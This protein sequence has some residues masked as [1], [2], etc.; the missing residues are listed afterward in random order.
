MN[1]QSWWQRLVH[2]RAKTVRRKF[3]RSTRR[4]EV[5]QLES[6]LVPAPFHVTANINIYVTGSN[7]G[8]F[9]SVRFTDPNRFNDGSVSGLQ[10]IGATN[11]FVAVNLRSAVADAA[12]FGGSNK[13]LLET[14]PATKPYK[15]SGTD[16]TVM[17][18][19]QTALTIEN[20]K[21]GS[22]L[23]IIDAQAKSRIFEIQ[24]GGTTTL[25]HLQMQNGFAEGVD[26]PSDPG[27]ASLGGAIFM[28]V[29]A[30]L[31]LSNDRLTENT[32][33]GVPGDGFSAAGGAIFDSGATSAGPSSGKAGTPGTPSGPINLKI[34]NTRVDHNSAIASGESFGSA[35]GAEGGGLCVV[36][37]GTVAITASTF[38][39]NSAVGGSTSGAEGGNGGFAVGAGAAFDSFGNSL[40]VSVANSTFAKNTAQ[41]G[42][43][44]NSSYGGGGNAYGGGLAV[45]LSGGEGSASLVNSTV[46]FN[47][48]TGGLG[49]GGSN[50]TAYGG[51]VSLLGNVSLGVL[52]TI[53]AKNTGGVNTLALKPNDLASNGA[54]FIDL[55]HNL[56]GATDGSTGFGVPTDFLGTA[57]HPIDP[58][59]APAGLTNNGGPTP[60]IAI[61]STSKAVNG[62]SDSVVT[63][64]TPYSELGLLSLIDDQRGPGFLRESGPHVDIGAFELSANKGRDLLFALFG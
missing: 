32:A 36:G 15:L 10:E 44:N 5:E 20:M 60:T 29:D 35:G 27:F 39:D 61:L 2:S 51:G 55:G 42:N 40:N 47:Q 1:T 57:A 54:P 46:A 43:A 18:S 37:G 49:S 16:L 64:G 3:G 59:F 26:F 38:D 13:I 34:V 7:G 45:F 28:D 33:E 63:G 4:M 14:N 8:N 17:F 53:V 9:T 41:A 62:G 52:N 19:G 56:I 11:N 21:G 48:A 24:S 22:N 30:V 58:G 23:S 6:R 50:G 12:A 31:T 25:D